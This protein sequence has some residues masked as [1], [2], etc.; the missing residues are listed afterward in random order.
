MLKSFAVLALLIG[1]T[2]GAAFAGGVDDPDLPPIDPPGRWRV[3]TH[4]DATSTSKCIGNPKTPLCA[5]ESWNACKLRHVGE[6]CLV[7][8]LVG[9]PHHTQFGTG[10]SRDRYVFYRVIAARHLR[11]DEIDYLDSLAG[12]KC[13]SP[14]CRGRGEWRTGDTRLIIDYKECGDHGATC[15]FPVRQCWNTKRGEKCEVAYSPTLWILRKVEGGWRIVD[16]FSR[17]DP[18]VQ[19]LDLGP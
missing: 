11:Q 8:I 12:K 5:V 2:A 15:Q 3:L 16:G 13:P 19:H 18:Y 6:L 17:T 7:A 1:A 9:A 14:G 10:P 4:D